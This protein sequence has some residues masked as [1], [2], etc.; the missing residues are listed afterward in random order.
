MKV[1]QIQS[2]SSAADRVVGMVPDVLDR[3]SGF[4]SGLGKK[5]AGAAVAAEAAAESGK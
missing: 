2:F 3:I 1:L 4:V 5:D